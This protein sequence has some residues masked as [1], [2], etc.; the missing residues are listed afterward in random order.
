MTAVIAATLGGMAGLLPSPASATQATTLV[1][2]SRH[3]AQPAQYSGEQRRY[4]GGW[5]QRREWREHRRAREE[6]RIAEAAR[7]EAYRIEQERAERRAWR[8]VQPERDGYYR[9]Y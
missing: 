2:G 7:R 8:H 1:G 3:L 5:D 6:A 9:G 4:D